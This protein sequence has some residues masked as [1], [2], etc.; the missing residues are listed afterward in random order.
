VDRRLR[1]HLP[2]LSAALAALLAAL[3]P[4]ACGGDES[5]AAD[6]TT[7]EAG[8]SATYALPIAAAELE[9]DGVTLRIAYA[10]PEPCQF[11]TTTYNGE[12]FVELRT[13]TEEEPAIDPADL[14]GCV[15][16]ELEEPLPTGTRVSPVNSG[17][18]PMPESELA[19]QAHDLLDSSDCAEVERGAPAFTVN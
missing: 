8:C 16:G 12:L 4:A 10:G 3:T 7:A 19:Q 13:S 5:T 11:A 1:Q 6:A 2:A 14:A 9:P 18:T 15:Q 17:P